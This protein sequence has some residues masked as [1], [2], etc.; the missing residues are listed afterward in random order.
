LITRL[1][2]A[3]PQCRRCYLPINTRHTTA[4]LCCALDVSLLAT[5][6]TTTPKTAGEKAVP[7]AEGN[8]A[9]ASCKAKDPSLQPLLDK[10]VG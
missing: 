5:G 9:L 4:V 7:K 6:C 3:F 2:R 8:A 10:T 1:A